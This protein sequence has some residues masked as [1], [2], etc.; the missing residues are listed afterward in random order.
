MTKAQR[1]R[2][3]VVVGSL[4]LIVAVSAMGG[5]LYGVFGARG[6]PEAWLVGSPFS[7]YLVPSLV[8][9]FVVG[10]SHL[11]AGFASL[12][13][14][15]RARALAFL[16]A[17]VLLVW[18]TTQVYVLGFVSFLQPLMAA[19]GLAVIATAH[20]LPRDRRHPTGRYPSG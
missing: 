18:I 20:F 13:G 9:L 8:L 5:G 15:P 2:L 3:H 11:V 7:D 16:S 17:S 12:A 10:G 1:T 6:I 14:S 4:L 19:W